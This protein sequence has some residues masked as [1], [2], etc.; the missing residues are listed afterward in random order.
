MTSDL[1]RI[2]AW[3]HHYILSRILFGPCYIKYRWPVSLTGAQDDEGMTAHWAWMGYTWEMAGF[4][5]W[6]SSYE[7]LIGQDPFML[8]GQDPIILT[9][10]YPI[11]VHQCGF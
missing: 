3:S 9:G 5:H 10:R 11:M 2:T 6:T 8:T 4:A 7:I 1:H